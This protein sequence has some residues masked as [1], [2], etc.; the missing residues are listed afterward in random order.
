MKKLAT[1]LT[2]ITVAVLLAVSVRSELTN[3]NRELPPPPIA[4]ESAN[5]GHAAPD[6]EHD[7]AS[8]AA[9]DL[10]TP[11]AQSPDAPVSNTGAVPAVRQPVSNTS[12][13]GVPSNEGA[14]KATPEDAQ[15]TDPLAIMKRASAAYGNVRSMRAN[16]TQTLVNPLLGRR[17][18]SRGTIFQQRPDKFLM[19]FSDPDGDVIV[20][21]GTA[22]WVYYPSSDPQQVIKAAPSSGA[23]AVDLQAQFLGDPERRFNAKLNGTEQ[24]DGR[25]AYVITLTPKRE[26]GYRTLKVWVDQRDYLARRFE[27][28]DMNNATR[29][30]NLSG[31][32][33]NVPLE[34]GLFRFTPPQ[35]ARIVERG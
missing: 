7:S 10:P 29:L 21:D 15:E 20:S 12:G 4:M 5:V 23:G 18:D 31:M 9:V 28:T 24:V 22:F 30:I 34:A 27:I 32:Q 25:A 2:A 8:P 33:T 3:K 14:E 1:G 19:R 6:V 11:V 13:G 17:I 35:G 26:E 16:F